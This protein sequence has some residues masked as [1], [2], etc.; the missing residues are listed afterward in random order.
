MLERYLPEALRWK[1]VIVACNILENI[2]SWRFLLAFM[3]IFM[4]DIFLANTVTMQAMM[5]KVYTY[6][7]L[8]VVKR[9]YLSK[10]NT[11]DSTVLF[12]K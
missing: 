7:A 6:M 4:N 9:P 3:Q 12:I 8:D 11:C 10:V 5:Q 2:M 1:K